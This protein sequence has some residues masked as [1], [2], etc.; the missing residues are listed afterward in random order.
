LPLQWAGNSPKC[1]GISEG[2]GKAIS[3]FAAA[4]EKILKFYVMSSKIRP[5][6]KSFLIW[7][8]VFYLALLLIESFSDKG[9]EGGQ[10][11]AS[12]TLSPE[13]RDPVI[14]QLLLFEVKNNLTESVLFTSPCETSDSVEVSRVVNGQSLVLT[15]FSDCGSKNI[16]GFSLTPGAKM[17]FTMPDFSADW[18][19]E[20]GRYQLELKLQTESGETELATSG[21][22]EYEN[23]GVFRKLFRSIVSKPIFNWLVF[24]TEK[25]PGHPF[26]WAIV[27]LTVCVR[28]LLFLPNQKAM[29]SQREMQKLQPKIEALKKKHG[30]NQQLIAMKT[31]ELYKSHKVNPMSS[32]LPM[33]AQMPFL[34][35]V[36][37]IVREGLSEHLRYLLYGFQVDV[38]LSVANNHFFGL[39]LSIPNIW[40]LPVLVAAAQFLALKLAMASS[41]KKSAAAEGEGMA[42]QMQ[43]MQKTMLWLLPIML[44][45]FTA[46]FPAGVGIYWLTSTLFG[47]GQQRLVNWQLDQPEVRR[48]TL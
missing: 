14:G 24:L 43:Q 10:V 44:G 4:F 20:A 22:F 35:G 30:K 21:E 27:I 32:C 2:F 33:L 23:V 31:M 15:D 19:S 18:F 36:Y 40:V 25:L 45:F 6:L 47:I 46:T 17:Q 26:G 38:D 37:F 34:I 5:F 12:I 42:A 13:T 29:R 48:K 8:A 39:D 41:K 3:L 11:A 1:H 9:N 28:L 16:K 7:F